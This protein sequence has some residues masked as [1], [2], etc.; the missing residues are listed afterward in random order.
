VS[1]LKRQPQNASTAI[2]SCAKEKDFHN[3]S[4]GAP[5]QTKAPG[6][7]EAQSRLAEEL[8]HAAAARTSAVNGKRDAAFKV[9]LPLRVLTC[10][11]HALERRRIARPNAVDF[12]T[13]EF[14]GRSLGD[15]G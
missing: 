10:L 8:V 12:F 3:R 7:Q 1:P 2:A 4:S 6:G 9:A 5:Y 11:P 15:I 14:P 13:R